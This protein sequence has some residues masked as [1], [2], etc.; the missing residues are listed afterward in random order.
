MN[1]EDKLLVHFEFEVNDISKI[2]YTKL[3]FIRKQK[4][5]RVL[6]EGFVFFPRNPRRSLF[7]ALNP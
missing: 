1:P 2:A 4:S 5:Q 7:L 3:Y 6:T